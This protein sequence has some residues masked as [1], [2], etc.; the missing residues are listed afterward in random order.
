MTQKERTER[1]QELLA[2]EREKSRRR[3]RAFKDL[4]KA[5]RIMKLEHEKL[6]AENKSLQN[7]LARQKSMPM[8]LPGVFTI[9]ESA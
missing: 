4:L 2:K 1:L 3:K 8:G 9:K 6:Q 5:H 7:E